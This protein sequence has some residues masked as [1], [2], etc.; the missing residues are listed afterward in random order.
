MRFE[1]ATA[2]RI[3]FGPGTL[4]EVGPIVRELGRRALITTGR[5]SAPLLA[6]LQAADVDT[7]TLTVAGEPTT[8]LVRNGVALARETG[9]DLVIGCGGGSAI[10]A[11][12]AIAALL[13]N[14]GDPLDY[15]EVVGRGQPLT[16][17]SAPCIAIPT[18]AG[19]GAEVTRN[20]VLASP[21]HGVK[22]SLRSPFMLPRLAIVDPELTYSLPADVTAST[23]LDALTQLIEPFTSIRANPLTDAFCREGMGRVARSLRRAYEN[24]A[25]AAAREDMALASLLGGLAL[26]NAG[27]GA[28]HG[29]A[30]VIGGMYPAPHGAVCAAFLPHVMAANLRGLRQRQPN[31]NALAR[32][33][34][35]AALLTGD[36]AASAEEGIRWVAELAHALQI[37]GL[38][39]YGVTRNDFALLIEKTAVASST[40]ANPIVLTSNE[41][42]EI[43]DAAL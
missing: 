5:R 14:G 15:L 20:A 40:K 26:A 10:D 21:E 42:R 2:N 7:V 11:G 1:F 9:C 41:L 23:G 36:P 31:A 24:G 43:L 34:E 32:Y 8:D 27:L 38:A 29:F 16:R 13:A 35:V 18:T 37:P 39:A 28:A 30:S 6:I 22:V 12:K 4:K 33:R 3:L 25:D 19:A 17:P